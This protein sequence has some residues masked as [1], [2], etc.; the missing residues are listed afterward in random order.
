MTARRLRFFALY[1][2]RF[3]GGFG[4]ITLVTLLP[5][6]VDVLSASDLMAGLFLAV[7]TL[8]QTVA[9]VPLAW[10]GDRHDKRLVLLGCLAL[11]IGVYAAFT[12]VG[13]SVELLVVRGAQAVVV[14]GMGLMSLALVGE[15]S[16]AAARA[17]HIGTANAFRF[18]ASIIGSLSAG[19]LYDRYGFEPVFYVIAGL[20]A[21]TFLLVVFVLDPDP[22]TVEGFPF[23]DLALSPRILALSSFRGQ[24]AVAVTLVRAWVAYFAG[25]PL[26]KGGLG[27]SAFAVSV[28]L[29]SE[30]ATN[31][32]F[33]P[34]T[35]RLS[36][37]FGRSLFVFAGGGA[38]GLV[39]LV[40]PFT[41]FLG[42]ALSAPAVVPL[43]GSV[44]VAF[45]P[46][47]AVNGLLGIADSFREPASMALFA[48]EGADGDG[49]ASSFG[50]RELVWR[51]GSV[52]APVVGGWLMGVAGIDAVFYLGGVAAI[53]GA[54]TFLALLVRQF[55]PNALLEW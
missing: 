26:A 44:S 16:E 2:T 38:Y 34:F 15:L 7:F 11:G 9:V 40:I 51:P 21:L 24:Y 36:D 49:V 46:L 20:F 45:L 29:V 35:G 37:R 53:A 43:V 52:I 14:T 23:A 10:A 31:M 1:W 25:L 22:T 13:S 33:Q 41:P 50:V 48:D 5:K 4:F 8:V 47:L 28:V 3:A 12:L 19:L 39:A 30:K 54:V 6:Y 42:D 18:A 55:G 32:F 27:Y 17:R